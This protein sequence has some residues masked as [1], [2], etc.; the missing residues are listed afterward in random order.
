MSADITVDTYIKGAVAHLEANFTDADGAPMNP[1][2]VKLKTKNPVGVIVE[3]IN[4][5]PSIGNFVSE[6]IVDVAGLWLYEWSPVGDGGD[7]EVWVMSS[8]LDA[9]TRGLVA[10]MVRSIM[11]ITW[12]RLMSD[13]RFGEGLIAQRIETVKFTWLSAAVAQQDE[14]AY[15]PVLIDYIAKRVA[16][17]LIPAGIE[18]WMRQKT[19]K[20]A[21]GTSETV[22]YPDTL[23]ALKELAKRLSAEVEILAG[24]PNVVTSLTTPGELPAIT[25]D[26]DMITEDP[27]EWPP[28]FT[29]GAGTVAAG[30]GTGE[31]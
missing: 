6:F 13:A 28:A 21:T 29:T 10:R 9:P 24:N 27:F 2:L 26:G 25:G 15:S 30:Q 14:T 8:N 23:N 12:N 1:P 4:S 11:P 3:Q 16:L 7:G 22:S 20:S 18:Y 19:T 5:N 17:S 31:V